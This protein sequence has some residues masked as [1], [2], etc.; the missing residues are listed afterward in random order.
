MTP[1]NHVLPGCKVNGTQLSCSC[2][3]VPASGT[4]VASLGASVLPGFTVQFSRVASDPEAVRVVSTGCTAQAGACTPLTTGESDAS[5]SISVVLKMHPVLRAV[6]SAP[7]T[8][9]L[10]CQLGGSFNVVNQDVATGGLLVNA[11]TTVTAGSGVSFTTIPGQPIS[12]AQVTDDTSLSSLASADPTCTNSNMFS[13]FFG[14][15]IEEYIASPTTKSIP[16]C[17]SP[18]ACGGLVNTAYN[19]GWR[20]FYF[21]DG[22]A[23]NNSAPFTSLGSETNA[24]T[25]VSP[26]Q[27]DINGNIDIYGALFSNS[28]VLNDLGTGTANIYGAMVTCASF[29]NNGNGSVAYTPLAL[30]SVRRA[31]STLVRVPGSWTDRCQL[32]GPLPTQ[33]DGTPV[34]QCN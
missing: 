15:T 17:S 23:L 26:A 8:C 20:A 33:R 29:R 34:I 3:A 24:V 21:P 4:A 32:L 6:P 30:S 28:S 18:S 25:I 12:E 5:A 7:L 10:S 2:P 22:L 31:T 16:G 11:G 14:S 27:I 19:D 9:G 13:A 1:A